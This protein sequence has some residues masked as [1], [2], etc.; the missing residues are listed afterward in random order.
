LESL[1]GISGGK[2][3]EGNISTDIFLEVMEEEVKGM[4]SQAA[5]GHNV[6]GVGIGVFPPIG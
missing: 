1:I 5:V 4:L 2:S 6:I 3:P